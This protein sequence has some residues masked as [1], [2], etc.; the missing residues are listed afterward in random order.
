MKHEAKTTPAPSKPPTSAAGQGWPTLPLPTIQYGDLGPAV[1]ILQALLAEQFNSSMPRNGQ[2]CS[3]TSLGL[4]LFQV[5]CNL[6][7]DG[8]CGPA[9]WAELLS[10]ALGEK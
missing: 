10:P 7:P 1:R 5:G 6:E 8:V 4:R 3:R 2:F 9:T